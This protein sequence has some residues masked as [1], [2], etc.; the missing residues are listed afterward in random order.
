MSQYAEHLP[1]AWVLV[2]VTDDRRSYHRIL[3]S[4][5]SGFMTGGE[6]WRFSSEVI[7]NEI[8]VGPNKSYVC[9]TQGD[10]VYILCTEFYNW[11]GMISQQIYRLTESM[12]DLGERFKFVVLSKEDA[13]TLLAKRVE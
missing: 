5:Y 3:C 8:K 7:E 6:R 9:R 1:D 13:L 11:S 12:K 2:Q 4:W 10:N